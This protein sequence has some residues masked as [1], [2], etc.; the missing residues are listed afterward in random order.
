M[1]P[2]SRDEFARAAG[3]AS[4]Y[5][6]YLLSRRWVP[7]DDLIAKMHA[8]LT[9]ETAQSSQK[10]ASLEQFLQTARDQRRNCPDD[11]VYPERRPRQP[12][13][14]PPQ[15]SAATALTPAPI[16]ISA[17]YAGQQPAEMDITKSFAAALDVRLLLIRGWA[18]IGTQRSLLRRA[19]RKKDR[20]HF[21]M[22][23]LLLAPDSD[24]AVE[25]AKEI[26]E[27]RNAMLEGIR[28]ALREILELRDELRLR[29]E[30]RK[31]SER[32]VWRLFFF[33]DT[34]YVS[35]FQ[36]GIDGD[37]THMLCFEKAQGGFFGA[38][39]RYFEDLWNRSKLAEEQSAPDPKDR[40]T[41][42]DAIGLLDAHCDRRL[43]WHCKTVAKVAREI[44][45]GAKMKHPQ[46][47]VD[48]AEIGALLHDIGKSQSTKLDHAWI[49]AELIRKSLS[50]PVNP[51]Y[52]E[53]LA[54]IVERHT[55]VGLSQ[56]EI[57]KINMQQNL[58]IPERDYIPETLEEIV[59]A[60]AD[61]LVVADQP[62]TFEEQLI[63]KK[64]KWGE[65]SAFV[66]KMQAWQEMLGEPSY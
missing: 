49:G 26:G 60:Y 65:D 30:I 43:I 32:P 46:L 47:D 37:Q 22:R 8:K 35:S 58:Q 18:I 4:T 34:V 52:R 14:S 38:Y 17:Q 61:K 57:Q 23:L 56:A 54:R 62:R 11:A 48:L 59:V 39:D 9:I 21:Q 40:L 5:A 10:L 64:L 66:H 27:T 28:Y 31:Y 55:G 16:I 19:L 7:P 13:G 41:F 45:E 12:S 3:I 44:A 63:E 33:D 1:S 2:P 20:E 25:R 6:Y 51:H 15:I 36:Q 24:A 50:L 29:I 42:H 53:V